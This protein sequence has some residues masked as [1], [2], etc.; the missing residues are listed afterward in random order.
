MICKNICLLIFA[1]STLSVTIAALGF[2]GY[3]TKPHCSTSSSS[4]NVK[5]ECAENMVEVCPGA[6]NQY[7]VYSSGGVAFTAIAKCPWKVP[8]Y[9]IG[10]ISLCLVIILI[11]LFFV[12]MRGIPVKTVF[13]LLGLL[14]LVLLMVATGLMVRDLVNGFKFYADHGTGTIFYPVTYIVNI[15]LMVIGT[16][17]TSVLICFG[18]GFKSRGG[19]IVQRVDG[20]VSVKVSG[21]QS[22]HNTPGHGYPNNNSLATSSRN[23]QYSQNHGHLNTAHNQSSMVTDGDRSTM[24]LQNQSWRR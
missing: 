9:V 21:N 20:P 1:L 18:R 6:Y 24:Q 23:I 2:V 3:Y 16:L 14:A 15:V 4:G 19:N 17:S 22:N 11:V 10:I 13:T 8:T 12:A 5:V 7:L